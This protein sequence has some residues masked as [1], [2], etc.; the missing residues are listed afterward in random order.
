M[1]TLKTNIKHAQKVLASIRSED[2]LDKRLS[3]KREGEYLYIPLIS[4]PSQKI[5][6]SEL[7][8]F[9]KSFFPQ[10]RTTQSFKT[11]LQD[12]L[13]PDEIENVKTSYDIVGTIAILEID[14]ELRSKEV[15]IAKALLAVNKQ[16]TTVL[17]K[18]G[19]HEGVFR[20]QKMKFLAGIDTKETIHIEN[21]VKMKVNVETV[22]FSPRLSTE[23]IRIADCIK[24]NE[25]V[26]VFFS[27]AAPYPLVF[28][29]KSSAKKIVGIEINPEGHKYGLENIKLNK[30]KNVE[31]FCGDVNTIVKQIDEKFDRICMPLPKTAD[32]FLDAA[33]A[34]LKQRGVIHFYDFLHE[35][36]FA[37]AEEKIQKAARKHKYTCTIQGIH[38]CGCQGIK[39]YRICVDAIV[40]KNEN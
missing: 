17:R 9:D 6:Q 35:D 23:R 30:I 16:I 2:L 33:F 34:I 19:S 15:E 1:I 14:L 11:I 12:I 25:S 20:S 22:Y 37:L 10:T 13:T 39:V 31:L 29:K 26:M 7:V 8:E 24:P 32:N 40:Q 27:G 36:E 38:T 4:K 21:G 28:A 3:T 18:D 5:P